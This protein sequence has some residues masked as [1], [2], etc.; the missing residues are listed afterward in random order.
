MMTKI[1]LERRSQRTRYA[2]KTPRLTSN[3]RRLWQVS[4]RCLNLPLLRPILLPSSASINM[5]DVAWKKCWSNPKSACTQCLGRLSGGRTFVAP[6]SRKGDQGPILINHDE[7]IRDI[8]KGTT[9]YQL[10]M[11]DSA[12]FDFFRM[13]VTAFNPPAKLATV[14]KSAKLTC[15]SLFIKWQILKIFSSHPTWAIAILQ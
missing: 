1:C 14:L 5:Q 2:M 11:T 12:L 13:V 9:M 15:H 10:V 7:Q 4:T 6:R 3:A 8:A